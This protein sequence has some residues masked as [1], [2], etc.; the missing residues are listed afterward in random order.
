MRRLVPLLLVLATVAAGPVAAQSRPD[1]SGKWVLDPAK[2]QGPMIPKSLELNVTQTE[3][4]LTIERNATGPAGSMKST[5]VYQLDGSM[6]TNTVGAN[7]MSMDLNSKATWTGDTLVIDTTAPQMQGGMKQV[8][9][10]SVEGGGKKLTVRGDIS[11]AGQSASA[12]MV[13]TKP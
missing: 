9:R 13:Y 1:F 4:L 2:S 11:I 5:L 12:T 7:G 10:W 8:E 6:S 3:K